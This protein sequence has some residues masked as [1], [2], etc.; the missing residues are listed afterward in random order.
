MAFPTPGAACADLKEFSLAAGLDTDTWSKVSSHLRNPTNQSDS[1]HIPQAIWVESLR[2]LRWE[3]DE[4]H[5]QLSPVLIGEL[6][7]CQEA[8]SR[9]FPPWNDPN[10]APY[11]S[12]WWGGAG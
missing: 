1:K 4:T 6:C 11:V 5:M 2:A 8:L 9:N 10:M 7:H 3:K 12:A